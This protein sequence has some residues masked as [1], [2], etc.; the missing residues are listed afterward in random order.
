MSGLD[1]ADQGVRRDYKAP[2]TDQHKIPTVQGYREEKEHREAQA[3]GPNQHKENEPSRIQQTKDAARDYWQDRRNENVEPPAD[4]DGE[5]KE[6]GYSKPGAVRDQSADGREIHHAKPDGHS[7]DVVADTTQSQGGMNPKQKRKF[8]KNRGDGKAEREVMDPVTHLPVTICDFTSTSLKDAPENEPP[9]GTTHRTATGPSNKSK[10]KQQ[11]DE[12]HEEM[13]ESNEGMQRVFPPPKYDAARAE[14][15]HIYTL[16]MSVGLTVIVT[17][18][19]LS[20]FVSRVSGTA[21]S[22]FV[23]AIALSLAAV[24]IY[25][26]RGWVEKRVK[27]LWDDELW[28]AHREETKRAAKSHSPETTKWLNGLLAAIWPLI[29]PDLFASLADTLEDVLQASLPRVVR[30]VSVEDL[31]QGSESIRILSVRWLP[32]G[33]AARSVGADGKLQ[34]DHKTHGSSD[35]TVPGEGQV[36]DSAKAAQDEGN[37]E[38][39]EEQITEGMEAEEGDFVNVEISFAYRAR[40]SGTNFRSRKKDA[41]LYLAFYLPG[42]V[43]LPVWVDLRGIVG[44]LRMRLQLAPDPPFFALCTMTFLGQPKVDL[45]CTPLVKRGLNI[46]DLPLISNFVQSAVDA[47]MAEYVAPKSL[48][49]DLKDMLEGDDFKKDTIARGILAV[50]VK[51]AYHFK[52]GDPSVPLIKDG[53]SDPYVTVG[54]AKFGKPIASTRVIQSES[55]PWWDETFYILVSPQELDVD[56]RLRLQLWDSDRMTADDDLGRVEVDLKHLMKDESTNGRMADR[57]DGFKALQAGE[58]MPGKLEWSVGYYS[59]TR[60]TKSQLA[61]QTYDTSIRDLDELM[62]RVRAVS[63]RKLREAGKDETAEFEQLQAQ[64][65]KNIED[66]MIISAPPPDGYPSG[67]LSIQIHQITGLELEKINK[68]QASKDEEA[69][70]DEETGESLPSSYCTIIVNHAKV[71]KT[72]TKPKNAKPFFNAGTERFI[73]DWRTAEVF[74]AVKDARVHE[75]DALLGVVHFPLSETF[76]HRSQIN[77]FYPL[78]GGVGFGRIRISMVW[79]AVQ[80]QAPPEALGWEVGTLQVEP[81]IKTQDLP[82]DLASLKLRLNTNLGNGKMNPTGGQ[83]L[84]KPKHRSDD[85]IHLA[86]RK[87]YSSPLVIEFKKHSAL[88]NSTP[89]FAVFWL[90][91]IPDETERTVELPVWK[92]DLNRARTC[93]L[94]Q[95]GERVGSIQVT[96]KFWSGLSGHHTKYAKSD[97]NIQ[98]V[99]EVLDTFHDSVEDQGSAQEGVDSNYGSSSADCSNSESGERH[100]R[101]KSFRDGGSDRRRSSSSEK[102]QE[103]GKRSMLSSAQDYK[104]HMKQLHRRNRGLMQWKGPRTLKWMST[105]IDHGQ[106]RVKSLFK[107]HERE[108]DVETEV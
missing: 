30:M 85:P 81:E 60:I 10:S 88:R 83:G 7:E 29:N 1:D 74:V 59:K 41:H 53:S 95:C 76:K 102:L 69:S 43:K 61:Q 45:A 13:E 20:V 55:E 82:H 17:A 84:W 90:K 40:P 57:V 47:A 28:E 64:E 2:Y 106:D 87:R 70:S 44:I 4:G 75:D 8:M 71:F 77:S 56:E 91:D 99:M 65:H 63:S 52:E 54:W 78:A 101:V 100:G 94:P 3:Q 67:V 62:A 12:E 5:R 15:G 22:S 23:S 48:T 66:R 49:L 80:L 16:A 51:H 46:M 42:S 97:R 39:G 34:P 11:L 104:K 89:A 107:H 68:R 18:C 73:K 32:T 38:Q 105:K 9:T 86:V 58:G 37:G 6:G 36:D 96:I 27:N 79:R 72:R 103:D 19:V 50:R 93:C 14:L 21:L 98:D 92:G 108:P 33:A 31:G 35:R 24:V 25:G 26:L